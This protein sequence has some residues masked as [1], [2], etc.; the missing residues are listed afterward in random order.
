MRRERSALSCFWLAKGAD[1]ILYD[2]NRERRA[3]SGSGSG[4]NESLGGVVIGSSSLW[5]RKCRG[6]PMSQRAFFWAIA[7]TTLERRIDRMD[8]GARWLLCAK[9]AT[10]PKA[11]PPSLAGIRWGQKGVKPALRRRAILRS[12]RYLFCIQPPLRTTWSR[13]ARWAICTMDSAKPL[14]KRAAIMAIGAPVFISFSSC[15][16]SGCQFT[17]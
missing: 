10:C 2:N 14:W 15:V 9:A 17:I 5:Y 4:K 16:I 12:H 11:I 13:A 1:G 3:V 6:A 8:Y 7:V